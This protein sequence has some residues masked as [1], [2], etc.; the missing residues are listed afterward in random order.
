M[1]KSERIVVV[2][3]YYLRLILGGIWIVVGIDRPIVVFIAEG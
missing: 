2:F 3:L 1:V